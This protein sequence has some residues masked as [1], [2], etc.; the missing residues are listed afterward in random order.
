M[1]HDVRSAKLPW[2]EFVVGVD[3]KVHQGKCK[4]CIQIKGKKNY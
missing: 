2:V 1:L 4:V 3:G